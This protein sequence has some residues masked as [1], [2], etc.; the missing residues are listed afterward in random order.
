MQHQTI[1]PLCEKD[2]FREN[3]SIYLNNAKYESNF[4]LNSWVKTCCHMSSQGKV[5][6]SSVTL[7]T[8]YHIYY[9]CNSLFRQTRHRRCI[10]NADNLGVGH[11]WFKG[12]HLMRLYGAIK[13]LTIQLQQSFLSLEDVLFLIYDSDG[14][15]YGCSWAPNVL[16]TQYTPY[17]AQMH[18]EQS[19]SQSTGTN[20]HKE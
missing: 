11:M 8:Y 2:H 15:W 5:V 13:H 14:I 18:D 12:S 6:H 16:C 20:I 19:P 1:Q 10:C 17:M 9:W 7:H 3:L 4:G